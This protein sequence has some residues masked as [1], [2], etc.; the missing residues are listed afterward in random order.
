M[1]VGPWESL[2]VNEARSLLG[3]V[4]VG[5]LIGGLFFDIYDIAGDCTAPVHL[6]GVAQTGLELPANVLGHE[7][8][9]SPDGMTYWATGLALGALT[10]IEIG[11][12]SW[13]ERVCTYG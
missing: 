9:F 6:N 4:S 3:A 13:R 2:K 12:A 7:G 8:D 10:A 5:P 1:L 11:R